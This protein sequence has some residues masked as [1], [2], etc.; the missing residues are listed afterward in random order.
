MSPGWR[1][2]TQPSP[3]LST[4]SINTTMML[5]MSQR[6]DRGRMGEARPQNKAA[7]LGQEAR[8]RA[9]AAPRAAAGQPQPASRSHA[10]SGA[11]WEHAQGAGAP[12]A[13][14]ECLQ[15]ALLTLTWPTLAPAWR[16]PAAAPPAGL[17]A[18]SQ[19]GWCP[20]AWGE[21]FAASTPN[22]VAAVNMVSHA[23]W[24]ENLQCFLAV[25]RRQTDTQPHARG[26]GT[27]IPQC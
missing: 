3:T 27:G 14:Q 1:G 6:S 2:P 12:P 23:A 19:E 10:S 7:A 9:A 11:H 20:P 21:G 24:G 8:P 5:E 22:H 26:L 15:Q 17:V 4:H 18:P 13:R 25:G 16:P